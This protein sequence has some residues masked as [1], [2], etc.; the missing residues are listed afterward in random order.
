MTHGSYLLF[1]TAS[2]ISDR[3]L[4]STHAMAGMGSR[5][6]QDE[7]KLLREARGDKGGSLKQTGGSQTGQSSSEDKRPPGMPP[8]MPPGTINT[9]K[10][11]AD[12]P[13][14]FGEDEEEY[15][16]VNAQTDLDEAMEVEEVDED[17]PNL[18]EG[19]EG[20]DVDLDGSDNDSEEEDEDMDAGTPQTGQTAS[21]SP[22]T[23]A[24]VNEQILGILE[25]AL[26]SLVS[27]R[28]DE[29]KR[30]KDTNS[31]R[32]ASVNRTEGST[33]VTITIREK[34]FAKMGR[35]IGTL[36]RMEGIKRK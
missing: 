27:V 33:M 34:N 31:M 2:A 26:V 5:S 1:P 18:G 9:R 15:H 8:M 30:M 17:E 4:L 36:N 28:G 6:N 32:T 25:P 13:P 19:K 21:I 3:P 16:K 35:M 11:R 7:H 12:D 29:D 20:A 24:R 14:D 23:T 22:T 10:E